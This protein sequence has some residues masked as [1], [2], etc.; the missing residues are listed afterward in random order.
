MSLSIKLDPPYSKELTIDDIHQMII[1]MMDQLQDTIDSEPELIN[2]YRHAS[3]VTTKLSA[4]K[5]R[6]A[7]ESKNLSYA[8]QCSLA[9]LL[10]HVNTGYYFIQ[11]KV[12]TISPQHMR[13]Q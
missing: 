2:T 1:D 6:V 5:L 11:D 4:I 13:G 10:L 3:E 12:F 8:D 9:G 7:E